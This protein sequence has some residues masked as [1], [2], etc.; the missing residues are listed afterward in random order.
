ME[1]KSLKGKLLVANSSIRSSYFA[2]TVIIVIE[3]GQ[4]GAFGLVLNRLEKS[5][6]HKHLGALLNLVTSQEKKIQFYEGGPVAK[7]H[8]SIIHTDATNAY[9]GEEIIPDVFWGSHIE[10][11]HDLFSCPYSFCLYRGYSG[12]APGQLEAEIKSHS[13]II[14]NAS[15]D[16]IFLKD[17]AIMWRKALQMNGGIYDYFA[18]RV[19]DPMLN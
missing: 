2:G 4:S 15:E 9:A 13:W 7:D 1:Y 10:L 19:K 8:M 14:A 18:K 12:W 11:L 3:H 16:I 6:T 17:P 5:D